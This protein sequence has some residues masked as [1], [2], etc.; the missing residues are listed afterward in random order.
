MIIEATSS[1][2]PDEGNIEPPGLRNLSRASMKD[3]IIRSCISNTPENVRPSNERNGF[4]T[5]WFTLMNVR[6]DFRSTITPT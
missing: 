5:D 4:P 1:H 3:S 2:P 6:Q